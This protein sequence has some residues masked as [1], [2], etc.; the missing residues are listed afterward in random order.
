MLHVSL[1]LYIY[2]VRFNTSVASDPMS[3]IEFVA[4]QDALFVTVVVPYL[5]GASH[6]VGG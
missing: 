4:V 3:Q 6:S 1:S 5:R 2:I